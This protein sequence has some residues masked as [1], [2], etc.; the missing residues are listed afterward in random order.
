MPMTDKKRRF[1][2]AHMAGSS[3]KD[4][5]I[6]A[7]YS[8]KTAAAAGSRLAKD[9]D[10]LAEIARKGAVKS[11]KEEA[12]E[13]GREINLPDLTA[14]YSDPKDFLAALM[15]DAQEDVKLRADAAKA[16]MPF[17]HQKKGESGK[18]EQRNEE[19]KKVARRFASSAP[20]KLVAAG[21][22]KV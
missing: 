16:L 6:A 12:K 17:F 13:A 22:K 1:A 11:A 10:V 20:P 5:A 8:E 18:K 14:M 7:G 3:N 19:A 2:A 15:N 21:G 9:N 4:A